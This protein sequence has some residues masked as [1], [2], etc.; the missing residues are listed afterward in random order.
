VAAN[1]GVEAVAE[2]GEEVPVAVL[3]HEGLPVLLP[4]QPQLRRQLLAPL[5]PGPRP[6]EGPGSIP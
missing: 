6:R 2:A 4:Q 5:P 3:G 1:E